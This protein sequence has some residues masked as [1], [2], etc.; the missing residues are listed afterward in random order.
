[1]HVPD[2][3]EMVRDIHV[4]MYACVDLCFMCMFVHPPTHPHTHTHRLCAHTQQQILCSIQI[5]HFFS[6]TH[7]LHPCDQA[8]ISI[9]L[10]THTHTH[11]YIL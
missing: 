1:M 5:E 4:R 11:V 3:P 10:F 9:S 7:I 2:P 8:G 6:A